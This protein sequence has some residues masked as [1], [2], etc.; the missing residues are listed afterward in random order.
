MKLTFA[1]RLSET[2][3]VFCENIQTYS[4]PSGENKFIYDFYCINYA[5]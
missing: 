1:Q 3:C 4:Y 2:V 5:S